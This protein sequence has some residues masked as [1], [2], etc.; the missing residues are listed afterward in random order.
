MKSIPELADIQSK[1]EN[2]ALASLLFI[3]FVGSA[4][5]HAAAMI[6]PMPSLWKTTSTELDDTIEI[7]AEVPQPE[8]EKI[9]EI[10]QESE[11]IPPNSDYLD[12]K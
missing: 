1:N 8:A 3:G 7:V 10:A 5:V 4:C 6:T 9:T 12:E 2:K 11:P